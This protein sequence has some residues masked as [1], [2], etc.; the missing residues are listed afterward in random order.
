VSHDKGLHFTPSNRPDRKG[1]SAV[2][3][4]AA[5]GLLL[6]GES[7]AVRAGNGLLNPP[8]GAKAPPGKP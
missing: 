6:M 5:G 1:L 3:E 2:V 8:D 4:P 7:G